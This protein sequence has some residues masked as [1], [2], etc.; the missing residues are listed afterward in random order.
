MRLFSYLDVQRD[1]ILKNLRSVDAPIRQFTEVR[2]LL[3]CGN[4]FASWYRYDAAA[5]ES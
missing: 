3:P 1:N 5:A 4:N 2:S